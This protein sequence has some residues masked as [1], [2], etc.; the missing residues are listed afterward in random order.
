MPVSVGRI[1]LHM[2]PSS[3]GAPDDLEQAIVDFIGGAKSKLDIAIQ[4]LESERIAQAIIAAKQRKIRVRLALEGDYLRASPPRRHPFQPVPKTRK[5]RGNEPNRELFAALLR[6]GIDSRTDYNSKIFHQKFIVR[7]SGDDRCVLTGSTNFTPTGTD[8]NFNHVVVIEDP[9][10]ALEYGREFTQ[11]WRGT[12]GR[13]SFDHARQP[14]EIDVSGVRVKPLFAPDHGPEMEIMKQMLKAR[15]RI[16]FAIFTFSNS[17]GIDDVMVKLLGSDPRVAIK[18]VMDGP[19]GG[20]K[21]APTKPLAAKGADLKLID[22]GLQVAGHKVNKLHHKLMVID[23][24]LI[25]V[26]SFNYTGPANNF[27]DENILIIGDLDS[28]DQTSID[29]QKKLARYAL[30]DVNRIHAVGRTP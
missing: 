10:V 14:K 29:R 23:E 13:H 24:Q 22:K 7:D 18:G 19:M 17:S 12:F 4:E 6:A 1:T 20:Q 11:L 28:T 27:N 30:D 15:R 3:L 25:I 21:W 2:G 26:G 8:G 5:R 16:D 9:D